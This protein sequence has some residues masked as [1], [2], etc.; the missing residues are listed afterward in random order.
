MLGKQFPSLR[1]EMLKRYASAAA[2]PV[3]GILEASLAKIP[4]DEIILAMIEKH[5]K[6][7]RTFRQGALNG[8]IR[9]VAVGRQTLDE[10]SGAFQ[11]FSVPLNTLR[12]ELL[13]ACSLAMINRP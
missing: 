9:D 7:G 11:E 6:D 5:A 4:D 1:A 13:H 2:K 10:I 8:A 12:K 3:Q